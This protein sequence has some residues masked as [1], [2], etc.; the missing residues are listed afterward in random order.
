M[1]KTWLTTS[2]LASPSSQV[3]VLDCVHDVDRQYYA[4]VTLNEAL[5]IIRV[6]KFSECTAVVVVLV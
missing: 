5:D 1:V 6:R 2:I 3:L 4:H